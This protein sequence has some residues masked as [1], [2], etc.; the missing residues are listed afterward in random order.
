MQKYYIK[1]L[2]H[3][4]RKSP[5]AFY[6]FTSWNARLVDDDLFKEV[7]KN[8]S[9]FGIYGKY[10]IFERNDRVKRFAEQLQKYKNVNESKIRPWENVQLRLAGQ[11]KLLSM[12]RNL[13]SPVKPFT[14]DMLL[15]KTG[16]PDKELVESG[17]AL[18]LKN[19]LYHAEELWR[20]LA[21][22][23][24]NNLA[25]LANTALLYEKYGVYYR[26]LA[27]YQT[28]AKEHEHP[29]TEYYQ[30]TRFLLCRDAEQVV[31]Q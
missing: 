31:K 26:A 24:P 29:W 2:V 8:Y 3:E 28:V 1:K 22:K 30:E 14:R 20:N 18:Y 9:F 23:N 5:P 27:N 12:F 11:T 19:D 16:D 13:D 4:I 15:P 21:E 25:A 10:V 6:I 17:F 7:K